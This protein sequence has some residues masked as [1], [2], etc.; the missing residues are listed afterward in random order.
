MINFE[1]KS[2]MKNLTLSLILIAFT[3]ISFSQE[4][5]VWHEDLNEA[6]AISQKENKPLMLFLQEVIGADGV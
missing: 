6:V 3:S 2:K 5:L 1:K 4:K